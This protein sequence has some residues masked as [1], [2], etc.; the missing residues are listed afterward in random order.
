M[1][2]ELRFA[3]A[4]RPAVPHGDTP[5]RILVL[6][7][8]DGRSSRGLIDTATSRRPEVVALDTFDALLARRPA[9]VA[10]TLGGTASSP[11]QLAITGLDDLHPDALYRGLDLFASL[12]ETRKRLLDRAT[13]AAAAAEVR[14]WSG[15][16]AS[17]ALQGT[18]SD[19]EMVARLLG[20]GPAA[21]AGNDSIAALVRHIVAPHV[22]AAPPGDQAALVAAV[23]SAIA[24]SMRRVLHDP[25][26]QDLESAWRGLDFLVRRI[27]T[28]AIQL[29]AMNLSRDEL[30]V[31]L[32]GRGDVQDTALSRVLVESTIQSPGAAPWALVLGLF[33]FG[34][35]AEDLELL[36]RMALIARAAGAPFVATATP[37]LLQTAL[38]SPERLGSNAPWE[39]LRALPESAFVGLVA[40]RF[41]LRLP[42]GPATDPISAFAF[43]EFGAPPDPADYLWGHP[44]LAVGALLAESFAAASWEMS[45]ATGLE[46]GGRPVHV[47]KR[48]G[49][50]EMNPCAEL[51]L[52]DAEADRL[53]R[54]GLMALQSIRGR[55]AVRLARV[56]SLRRPSAALAGRWEA[57]GQE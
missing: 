46:L 55:D 28:D 23:D 5:F 10:L 35:G 48:G 6:G 54:S 20:R 25:A 33:R 52:S 37:D 16:A 53:S 45:P 19:A 22:V 15:A 7:D 17:S 31:D 12:R 8:F 34:A 39:A 40:T 14:G 9:Q 2:F 32:S 50:S 26:F 51:W 1:E 24:E 49:E 57:V 30:V 41:L 4:R 27:E 3:G 11:L 21:P 29:F 13:Y 44:A 38:T 47:R 56:Q 43:D 42:Y 18:G 36:G